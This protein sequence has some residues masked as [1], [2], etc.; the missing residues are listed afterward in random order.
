VA[1]REACMKALEVLQAA[2]GM[3]APASEPPVN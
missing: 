3:S 1:L 2:A